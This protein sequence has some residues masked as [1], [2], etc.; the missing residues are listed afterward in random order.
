LNT[1]RLLLTVHYL[2]NRPGADMDPATELA[3]LRIRHADGTI[4]PF[5]SFSTRLRG[6]VLEALRS[7]L[8]PGAQLIEPGEHQPATAHQPPLV[9]MHD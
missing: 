2:D 1:N 8:P 4:E 7:A 5:T 6:S 9:V 3:A